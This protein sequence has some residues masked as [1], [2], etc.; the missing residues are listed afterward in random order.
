MPMNTKILEIPQENH[1]SPSF[2]RS[3]RIQQVLEDDGKAVVVLDG[4]ATLIMSSLSITDFLEMWRPTV[5]GS[6]VETVRG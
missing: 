3:D 5:E 2:V 4:G 6:S 1:P